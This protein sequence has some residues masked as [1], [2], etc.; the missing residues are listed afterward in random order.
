MSS[1]P[2]RR[3][4]MSTRTVRRHAGSSRIVL[5]LVRGL[6]AAGHHV[7]VVADRLDAGAVQA[8]GGIARHP[9]GSAWLQSLAVRLLPRG[10]VQAIRERAVHRSRPDLVISD[11]D[12][13]RQDVVLLHNV[14]A[15]EI[16]VLGEV[17]PAE[18]SMAAA[19]A[20]VLQSPVLRLVVAN[21]ALVRD[22]CQ[23]RF[24]LPA[25]RL[26]VVHPGHDP[27]QFTADGRAGLRERVRAELG[28]APGQFLVAF[29]T[30]GH[31][32]LRGV[33]I[34]A[35]TLARLPPG[36]RARLRLLA[37][38]HGGNIALLRAALERQGVAGGLIVQPPVDGVERYYHA[39]D[40]LFHP[41][42]F[43]TF[44]LVCLEAAACGCPVL[45]SRTVGASELFT[46]AGSGGV[47]DAPSVEAFAP[48]LE[49]LMMDAPWQAAVAEGQL[50]A[51]RVR[52]WDAYARDFIAVLGGHG[53]L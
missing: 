13:S 6:S 53:L 31:F 28:V 18:H 26:A 50:A 25:R 8:A 4:V 29:V 19:Q 37:V 14:L 42:L 24:G 12:L 17:S 9:L 41:A 52:D 32:R 33:D 46:G 44:G 7:E 3:I 34:L 27:R 10:R 38:G 39:A 22:E 35:G 15:R 40:L 5:A 43:E 1:S 11:G 49:R 2:A 51:A 23:R 30:S 48:V 21:S 36:G 47:V 20:R 16:E 45:T